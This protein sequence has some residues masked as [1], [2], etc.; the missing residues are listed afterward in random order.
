MADLTTQTTD[1]VESENRG[2]NLAGEP[3]LDRVRSDLLSALS[4]SVKKEAQEKMM[5]KFTP[6]QEQVIQPAASKT[7]APEPKTIIDPLVQQVQRDINPQQPQQ[8]QQPEPQPRPDSAPT[9]APAPGQEHVS[10]DKFIA[11]AKQQGQEQPAAIPEDGPP[12][13]EAAFLEFA[14]Q[15]MENVKDLSAQEEEAARRRTAIRTFQTDS[16]ETIRSKNLS[17]TQIATAEQARQPTKFGSEPEQVKQK[18]GIAARVLN[19][20]ASI[21]LIAAGI[22]VIVFFYGKWRA[23]RSPVVVPQPTEVGE[24]SNVQR[25][26]A[27]PALGEAKD[28]GRDWFLGTIDSFIST[29]ASKPGDIITFNMVSGDE[30]AQLAATDFLSLLETSAADAFVRSLD[31]L[32]AVGVRISDQKEPFVLLRTTFFENAFAGMLAWEKTLATDLSFIPGEPTSSAVFLD[33]LI[34][35]KNVR[36]LT[37]PDG[38]IILLYSF[39]DDET[40][41]ITRNEAAFRELLARLAVVRFE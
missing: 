17:I 3:G 12:L 16:S 33:K 30:K 9:N 27:L 38:T 8:A 18:L 1:K 15:E 24:L 34:Q 11:Y 40:I 19:V 20:V 22:G 5:P 29:S 41:I 39:A 13:G 23:D 4:D 32:F 31:D 6:P 28:R 2:F 21:V 7:P 25:E 26:V 36:A 10:E 35:N 14:H 37:K